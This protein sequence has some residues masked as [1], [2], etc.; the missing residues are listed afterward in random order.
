[1]N[2]YENPSRAYGNFS[3]VA[4]ENRNVGNGRDDG[5]VQLFFAKGKNDSLT[6]EALIDFVA[7]RAQIDDTVIGSIKILEAFSFFV[8]PEEDAEII[9]NFFQAEAGEGKPIVARAKRK[10]A[11]KTRDRNRRDEN[12]YGNSFNGNHSKPRLY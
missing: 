5:K 10:T 12:S 9:L 3:N 1:M 6:P 7:S 2:I 11:N 8:V 4:R